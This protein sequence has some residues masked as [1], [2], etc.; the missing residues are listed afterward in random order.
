MSKK[1]NEINASAITA[2][3][4]TSDY[5][6]VTAQDLQAKF[7]QYPNVSLR[8][9]APEVKVNYGILLKKSKEPVVGE[10]YNPEATNWVALATVC[11]TIL[12]RRRGYAEI[13]WEELNKG[14]SRN[15][16]TLQKDMGAFPVGSKVYLRK[17]NE[18]PYEVVYK[19]ETHIVIQLLGTQE[20]I[21]WAHNTFLIN[22]PVFEPRAVKSSKVNVEVEGA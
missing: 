7:E 19:T 11:S 13:N 18:T 15:T 22:G 1:V 8:K 4:N 5:P 6:A 14:A 12:E 10:A 21:C 17:N 16:A 3:T 9:L 2:T 20:P